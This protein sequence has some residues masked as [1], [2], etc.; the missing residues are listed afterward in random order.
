MYVLLAAVVTPMHSNPFICI[1]DDPFVYCK[2]CL[3]LVHHGR[4][5]FY[6]QEEPIASHDKVT[7]CYVLLCTY[8]YE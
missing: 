3:D 7:Y 6:H 8:I 1:S 5:R 2:E 4:K